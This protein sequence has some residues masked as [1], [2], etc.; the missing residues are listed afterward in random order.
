MAQDQNMVAILNYFFQVSM[1]SEAA[2]VLGL[3]LTRLERLWILGPF[4]L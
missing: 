2:F 1:G 4:R 3:L